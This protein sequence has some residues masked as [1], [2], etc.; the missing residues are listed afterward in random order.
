[1]WKW[2]LG[3]SPLDFYI[4][5]SCCKSRG[6]GFFVLILVKDLFVDLL[7]SGD[8]L[9]REDARIETNIVID[10]FVLFY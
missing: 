4:T 5:F 8:A 2:F 10:S 9:R 6:K 7:P 3:C 1:M